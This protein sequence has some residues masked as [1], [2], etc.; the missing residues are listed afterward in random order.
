MAYNAFTNTEISVGKAITQNLWQK[1]KDDFDDHETRI[2][3]LA[4]GSNK[5]ILFNTTYIVGGSVN[6]GDI[7]NTTRILYNV[8]IT[9]LSLESYLTSG[10][11]TL[12]IDVLKG[13]TLDSTIATSIL[14]SPLSINF[15]GV[16][17]QT[18]FASFNPSFQNLISGD[19][20]FIKITSIPSLCEKF[21]ITSLGV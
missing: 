14:T 18:V 5:T 8:Q 2:S 19:Y 11:G 12:T 4:G 10:T 3:S 9:E 20:L 6:S 15:S 17:Y 21:R 7:I 13:T 16:D 1:V